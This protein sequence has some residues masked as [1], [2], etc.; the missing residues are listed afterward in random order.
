MRAANLDDLVPL[1]GFGGEVGVQA[2]ECGNQVTRNRYTRGNVHGGRKCV[3]RRLAH[4]D[5]VVWV[6]RTLFALRTNAEAQLLIRQ[7][8]NDFIGVR[9][10]GSAGAGLIYVHWEMHVMLPGRHFAAGGDDRLSMLFAELAEF[11]VGT[12]ARSLQITERMDHSCR[13]WFQTDGKILDCPGRGRAIECVGW[14]L[15]FAHRVAFGSEV[16]HRKFA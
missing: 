5:M 13:H 1:L 2:L 6:D 10:R 11:L 15:H 12:R 3:V 9:V 4:V 8:G 7:I 14:H 16:A